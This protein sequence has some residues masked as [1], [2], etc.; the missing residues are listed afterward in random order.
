MILTSQNIADLLRITTNIACVVRV[1]CWQNG[2]EDIDKVDRYPR[3][4][5]PF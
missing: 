4:R 5:S 3:R 2:V 1:Y